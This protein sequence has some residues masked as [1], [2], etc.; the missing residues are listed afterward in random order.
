MEYPAEVFTED[1]ALEAELGIDSVKQ[2]ELLGKL[3]SKY[4][5][6]PR[7]EDFRLSD[8]GTLGKITD[9]VYL[10]ISL[11][12]DSVTATDPEVGSM[13]ASSSAHSPA[14]SPAVMPRA[15]LQAQ[16][17]ELFAQAME[18]PP[19]VFTEDVALEAEL[20]ID[21]VK[22]GAFRQAGGGISAARASR[23][24]LSQRLRNV[25]QDHGLRS[26]RDA[27]AQTSRRGRSR[28]GPCCD[29]QS[30]R[31]QRSRVGG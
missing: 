17:V 13:P 23:R 30:A 19:E 10:A 22:Q 12:P 1:V 29:R 16:I 20:G 31:R 8:Y 7:P 4:G 14:Q 9:F 21:S 26:Q 5:L 15:A 2:M 25:G 11:N 24:F 6:P 28:L 18:Y 27:G 3:E